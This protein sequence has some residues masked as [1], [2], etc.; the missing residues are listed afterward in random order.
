M[1]V[2]NKEAETVAKAILSEWLCKFNIPAQI[3]TDGR[4][5]FI[6]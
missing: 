5:E 4:K 1:A 3:H 2:E 6:N